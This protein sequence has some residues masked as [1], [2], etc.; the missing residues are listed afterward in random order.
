MNKTIIKII[1][2]LINFVSIFSSKFAAHLSILLFS[3]PQK[4]KAKNGELEYLNSAHKELVVYNDISIMT[5]RWAGNKD[6][7]LLAH[8]W[9]SNTYRWKD[10]IEILKSHNYN[11]IS[12]DAPA[13]G[14]SGGKLFNALIY[15]ECIF[16]VARK[17]NA[18][19]IIGHSVGGMATV[20]GQFKH[21]LPEI[22]KLVLLGSPADFDGVFDRYSKMMGYNNKVITAMNEYVLKHYNHLPE[23]YSA[24]DFS[25]SIKA[26]GLIIHDK[27]DRIIPFKDG[28]KFKQNYENSEFISTK[29][30]G[31]GLKSDVVYNYIIDFLKA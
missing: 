17:F 7:I 21:N 27:K 10:L 20:F 28:L 16:T 11:I 4:G 2:N 5:Y 23:Y 29:G 6:T 9:E 14:N 26:K 12:I 8:G 25:K 18:N 30:F 24:A 15:S 13:H 22:K 19:V 1:G 3:K 31:H